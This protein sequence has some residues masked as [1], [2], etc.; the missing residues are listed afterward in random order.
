MLYSFLVKKFIP[1][2]YKPQT[3]AHRKVCLLRIYLYSGVDAWMKTIVDIRPTTL[4]V[5]NLYKLNCVYDR[6]CAD[7]PGHVRRKVKKVLRL[8]GAT[9][10]LSGLV[11]YQVIEC[12]HPCMHIAL[13]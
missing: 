11:T 8:H 9:C 3:R 6:C 4:K 13:S 2:I 10:M 1:K 12:V 5:L 7:D